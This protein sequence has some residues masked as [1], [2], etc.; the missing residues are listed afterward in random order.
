MKTQS[1]P[2]KE[3]RISIRANPAQKEL[4]KKAAQFKKNTLSDFILQSACNM[5]QETLISQ[6]QFQ[7]SPKEW[8][9]FCELL[10]RSPRENV[11]LK[12]LL[13]EPDIFDRP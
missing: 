10:D 11:A 5:A 9:A 1:K 13:T 8:K 12:K 2:R 3:T 7:L 4:L 6:S